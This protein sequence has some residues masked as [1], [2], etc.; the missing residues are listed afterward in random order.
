M[1]KKILWQTRV[2]KAVPDDCLIRGY[3]HS[4]IIENLTYTEA[5]FLTLTGRLP[6]EAETEMMNAILNC[7]L[8]LEI[9]SVT[10][11]V[12]RHI[13]SGNPQVAPAVAGGLLAVGER[14]TSPQDS[15]DLINKAYSMMEEQCLT[16]EQTARQIVDQ[17][18]KEKKRIPGFGHPSLKYTDYRAASLRKVAERA[19][20]I[21]EKTLL[22]EAIHREFGEQT[23]K[24]EIPINVDGMMACLMNEMGLDPKVMVSVA[25]LSVQPG[26][27][28][29]AI[30][31]ID[32]LGPLR[33]PDPETVAYTGEPE[34]HLLSDKP[35]SE[36]EK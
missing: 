25:M 22:Y 36:E 10:V 12:A 28:A 14:T 23:G 32:N 24:P 35:G 11:S 30:E 6:S 13:V 34:R 29:H 31:E 17:Y 21:G 19:G 27:M 7:I 8:E 4:E 5:M 3:P 1:T 26:I 33:Y 15:A 18:R 9:Q 20:I 2:S 16:R